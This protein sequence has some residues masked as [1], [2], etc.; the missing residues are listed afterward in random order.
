MVGIG[1]THTH[2]HTHTHIHTHTHTPPFATRV[3]SVTVHNI[4]YNVVEHQLLLL[5]LYIHMPVPRS[6]VYETFDGRLY[7]IIII[8]II[9]VVIIFEVR[10]CAVVSMRIRS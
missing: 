4:C 9:M 6:V 7:I 3:I 2:T 1:T 8:I 10:E 5:L